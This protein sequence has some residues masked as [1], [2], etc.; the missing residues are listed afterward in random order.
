MF[1]LESD[2]KIQL[3]AMHVQILHNQVFFHTEDHLLMQVDAMKHLCYL[4]AESSG[5]LLMYQN[6]AVMQFATEDALLKHLKSV[7]HTDIMFYG[8]IVKEDTEMYLEIRE[9]LVGDFG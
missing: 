5:Y 6:S 7:N 9:K 8:K 4:A 2:L 1:L 3:Q